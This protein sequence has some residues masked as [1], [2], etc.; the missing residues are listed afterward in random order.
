MKRNEEK[1]ENIVDLFEQAVEKKVTK[2]D[3]SSLDSLSKDM[4]KLLRLGGTIGNTEERLKRLKE[5]YRE[6]SE[7]TIPLKMQNMGISDIRMDDGSRILVE[8]FYSARITEKNRNSAHYWLRKNDLG[9]IIKN[10][11]SVTFGKGEDELA[12]QTMDALEKQ[13]LMPSQ[14]ESVHPSTL[15]ATIRELI[16]SGN[17]AFDS[18]TQKLFSVYTGQRTKITK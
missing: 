15:K 12:T 3:D 9:D 1:Q 10:I 14:K 7:E 17:T 16:E 4:D 8:P 11:V 6:L 2:L 18:G 13:D 5:A